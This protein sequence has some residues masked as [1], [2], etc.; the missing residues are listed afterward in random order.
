MS[1]R[2]VYLT[3]VPSAGS[4][5][6]FADVKDVLDVREVADLLGVVPATV[7][8]EI[9]RDRLQHF[10]IGTRVKVTKKALLEY[11]ERQSEGG[12]NE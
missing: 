2:V 1:G 12:S 6:L 3:D 4:V 5:E 8:R 7:R 10:H 9:A 11:V